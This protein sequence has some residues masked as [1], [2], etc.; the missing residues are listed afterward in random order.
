MTANEKT[1]EPDAIDELIRRTALAQ[2]LPA[3]LDDPTIAR[4]VAALIVAGSSPPGTRKR[5]PGG[6]AGAPNESLRRGGRQT[7]GTADLTA[8]PA[9]ATT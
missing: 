9:K 6:G 7:E 3:D 2:G 1:P 4:R 8:S 5:R